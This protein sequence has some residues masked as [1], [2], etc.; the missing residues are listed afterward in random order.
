VFDNVQ[1]TGATLAAPI[2]VPPLYTSEDIGSP[3][4]AGSAQY[5]PSTGTLHIAGGGADIWG[6]SDQFHYVHLPESGDF[7]AVVQVYLQEN[8]D[9]WA[10]AGIMARDGTADNAA[11]VSSRS[12]PSNG[13]GMQWRDSTGASS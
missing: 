10:K 4:P 13:T 6:T 2:P 1:L 5:L 3:A 8:T 11:Y 9:G 12:T 7:S